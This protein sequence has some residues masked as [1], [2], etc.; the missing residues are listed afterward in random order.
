[1]ISKLVVFLGEI[2]VIVCVDQLVNSV[3]IKGLEDL[4]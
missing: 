4:L 1:M 2:Y 3:V